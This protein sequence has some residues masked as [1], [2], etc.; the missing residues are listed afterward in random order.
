MNAFRH[1]RIQEIAQLEKQLCLCSD[2]SKIQVSQDF[3]VSQLMRSSFKGS[4]R[5][6]SGAIIEDSTLTMTGNSSFGNG[7]VANVLDE[8]GTRSLILTQNM[9]AQNAYLQCFWKNDQNISKLLMRLFKEDAD[10]F[11]QDTMEIGE[12]ASIR[13]CTNI[14][15][16]QIG[17]YAVLNGVQ[18]LI[19]GTVLSSKDSPTTVGDNVIARHF[20][21]ARGASLTDGA[22]IE[23]CFVGE[24][25]LVSKQFSATDSVIFANCQ[26]LHGEATAFFAGPSTISHHKNT[27]LIAATSLFFNAGSGSN[28]SNHMY[29]SGPIHYGIMDRGTKMA[30]DSY[31]PWPSRIGSFSLIIGKHK[32]KLNTKDLPFSYLVAEGNT[33]RIIPAI[34]LRNLGTF[35]D[36]AKWPKRDLRKV[37]HSDTVIYE[38]LNPYTISQI[39]SGFLLLQDLLDKNDEK[40]LYLYDNQH[41]YV[42][43]DAALRA[44]SLYQKALLIYCGTHVQKGNVKKIEPWVDLGG[45]TTTFRQA[46]RL[47]KNLNSLKQLNERIQELSFS[48][49]LDNNR[50]A[51]SLSGILLNKESIDDNDVAYLKKKANEE[52]ATLKSEVLK[53]AKKEFDTIFKIN[54]GIDQGQM[55]Q[56]K[57]FELLRGKLNTEAIGSLIDDVLFKNK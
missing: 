45:L 46:R 39:L 6:N 26:L 50:F 10:S 19:N 29:K 22:Q 32:N 41:I 48:Y 52:I 13:H 54:Y 28:Q 25:A 40:L 15:N 35:R 14:E 2:W 5:I 43:R 34:A 16:V 21:I 51:S 23:N 44:I 37:P 7:T 56:E 53:D 20:I 47:L 57:E 4:F 30:S 36:A 42:T 8:S 11:F 31:I 49:N 33:T 17:P 9:N 38:L 24:N 18:K 12:N 27:L 1:L 3:Q 55:A